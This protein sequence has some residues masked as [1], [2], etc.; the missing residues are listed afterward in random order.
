MS[1]SVFV[2]KRFLVSFLGS[3][4]ALVTPFHRKGGV[5]YKCLAELVEWQIG[6]GTDGIVCCG[7]TGEGAVLTDSEK[8]RIAETCIRTAAK[9]IPILVGTGTSDTRQSV[10]LTAKMAK[11]GADGCLVVTPY[12]NKPPARGCLLH[13]KEIAQVGLP[14]VV[15]HNPGRTAVRFSA[16]TVAELSQIPGIAAFKDSSH[17]L[18]L[19]RKIRSLC[20]LPIFSGAD[21]MTFDIMREGGA[22]VIS[23]I[24]NLIPRSWKAMVQL[25][26][27]KKWET[28]LRL[29]QFYL[30][31]CKALVLETNP[32][33]VKWA[34]EQ[35]D[36][37]RGV[38]RLPLVEPTDITKEA[39]RKE[40]LRLSLPLFSSKEIAV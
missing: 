8:Q 29:A 22:G 32:Q 2:Q 35:F 7:S 24:G 40:L 34:M 38:C 39:I 21:D 5:D 28:A 37:C 18:E 30:P 11:L 23:V 4:V 36:R 10:R 15:Y 6:E 1:Q 9:R 16:E 25:C 13:F 33:C 12:Y 31:L 27:E 26:I 14:V 3:Y 17:D 20:S 19:V